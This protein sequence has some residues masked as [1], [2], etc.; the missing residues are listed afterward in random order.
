MIVLLELSE[1]VMKDTIDKKIKKFLFSNKKQITKILSSVVKDV[2]T[3][4][5]L[6]RI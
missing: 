6:A 1:K 5:D 4:T 2:P 3:L